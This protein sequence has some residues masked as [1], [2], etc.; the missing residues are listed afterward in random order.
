MEKVKVKVNDFVSLYEKGK[1]KL[2]S[3]SIIEK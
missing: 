3:Y 2:N 1:I